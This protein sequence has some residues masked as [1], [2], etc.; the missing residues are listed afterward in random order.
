MVQAAGYMSHRGHLFGA[1]STHMNTW[2]IQTDGK[3][4]FE[5]SPAVPVSAQGTAAEVSA[6][7]VGVCMQACLSARF[8]TN[9]ASSIH[10]GCSSNSG[11]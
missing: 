9:R 4:N 5:I 6:T 1:I 10:H 11:M 3:G 7:E 2:I 8:L